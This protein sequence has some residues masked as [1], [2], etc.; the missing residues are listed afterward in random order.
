MLHDRSHHIRLRSCV[1]I[2]PAAAALTH[3]SAG[4]LELHWYLHFPRALELGLAIEANASLPSNTALHFMTHAWIIDMAFNCPSAPLNPLTCPTPTQ[5][6]NLTLAI[7][8]GFITW[9]AFPFN[10]EAE[11]H[12]PWLLAAGVAMAHRI[13]DQFHVPHK[14]VMSQRDVPGTTRGAL[15][16]LTA[17]GVRMISIGANGASSPAYVPRAF[18]WLDPASGANVTV[19]YSPCE[20]SQ[21]M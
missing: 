16:T 11:L 8:K 13:D 14:T 7:N 10:S 3:P 20:S 4:V 19:A 1:R 9:H 2:L 17:A 15:P 6:A 18:T 5:L 12:S 21:L